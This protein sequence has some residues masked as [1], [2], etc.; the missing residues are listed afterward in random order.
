MFLSS[1]WDPVPLH[2]ALL[3]LEAKEYRDSMIVQYVVTYN[4]CSAK[5]DTKASE[6][7]SA[8]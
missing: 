1:Q 6:L 2:N 4:P 5:T 8:P 7:K 3:A